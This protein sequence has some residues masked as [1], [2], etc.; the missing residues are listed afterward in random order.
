MNC[1]VLPHD[2][3]LFQGKK[4][5]NRVHWEFIHDYLANDFTDRSNNTV[6]I[7]FGTEAAK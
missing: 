3:N 7:K 5:L 6:N 2:F 4:K 1:D